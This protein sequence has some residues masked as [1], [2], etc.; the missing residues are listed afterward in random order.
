MTYLV[1]DRPLLAFG[2]V[3]DHHRI[4]AFRPTARH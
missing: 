2:A 3:G 1:L 4:A